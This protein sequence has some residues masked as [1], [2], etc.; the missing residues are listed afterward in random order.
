MEYKD[1]R[2]TQVKFSFIYVAPNF[3]IW[4]Q[5]YKLISKTH[6]I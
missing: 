4:N 1:K 6:Y 3:H 5:S 2:E